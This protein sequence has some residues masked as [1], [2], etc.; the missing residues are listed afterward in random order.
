[1]KSAIS[2]DQKNEKPAAHNNLALSYFENHNF[3]E[4]LLHYGK[5]IQIEPSAVHYNNRGLAY[6]H[7]D[8]L[9]EARSDFDTALKYNPN[10]PTIYF[11]RG[12]VYLN[13]S[14]EPEFEK[15]H[16]DYNIALS[17]APNN[18]K[19]WHSKGL[20]F[21]AE[22]ELKQKNNN[23]VDMELYK[24]AIEMYLKALEVQENFMSSRFHLGLM[25]HKT[26]RFTDALKCFSRVL[27]KVKDD[28]TIYIARGVVYQDMGNHQ[29]AIEDFNEAINLAPELSEGYFRRGFSYYYQ[30]RFELAIEDFKTAQKKELEL[31]E[32]D[33]LVFEKNNG[34]EDGLGCCFHELRN[35][36][37]AIHHF[38]LAIERD[39]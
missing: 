28:K 39:P 30:K 2:K 14:P 38:D 1:M 23:I 4:A 36:E 11:N 5:A 10:D 3:E 9:D 21:Q 18:P 22:G 27:V 12:N 26:N 6:F 13:W 7:C 33:D 16:E 8:K 24:C 37:E 32:Q 19:L 31:A 15:A 25:Y 20:A 17:I 35:F 29:L 34:I